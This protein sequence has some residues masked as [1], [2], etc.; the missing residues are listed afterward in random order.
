MKLLGNTKS[1]VNK[2]KNGE[3]VS[4]LEINEIVLMHCDTVNNYY[5]QDSEASRLKT[6]VPNKSFG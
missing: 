4:Y 1:R 6:C 3:N 2:N 5:D